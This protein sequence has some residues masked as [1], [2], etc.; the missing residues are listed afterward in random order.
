MVAFF[1]QI[2][3]PPSN[4]CGHIFTSKALLFDRLKI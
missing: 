2:N 4:R 3:K 1:A